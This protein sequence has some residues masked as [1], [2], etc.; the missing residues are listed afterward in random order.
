M[1]EVVL[2]DAKG[3][4]FRVPV[5]EGLITVRGLGRVKTDGLDRLI[6]RSL[7]VDGKTYAVLEPSIRDVIETL[8][9][10]AQIVGPKDGPFLLFNSDLRAGDT[11]VEG[12]AGSGALT[13]MLAHAVAPSGHVVS[14]DVRQDFLGV[15]RENVERAGYE[16]VVEFREADI[17]EGIEETEV[18]AVVLDLP[19]PWTAL[20]SAK[21]ALRPSGHLASYSPTV[22]QMRETVL[23]L[24]ER[25]FADIWSVELLERR[26][27]VGRGTR[28]S[29]Q[30]LGH[31]GYM[32]FARR[33]E[34][35][36]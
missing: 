17:S 18:K 26:M 5:G 23:A 7:G 10:R 16:D 30:T 35:G 28:P 33:M 36:L 31:T 21:Q 2:L 9:R 11:V 4:K 13:V 25:G 24:R 32:T 1:R 12:G 8:R 3:Q 20:P 29:F 14:Y 34:N 27:E 19:E 22:E 15:A 6:G